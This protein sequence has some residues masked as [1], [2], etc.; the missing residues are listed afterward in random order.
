M[1]A[2]VLQEPGIDGAC[3]NITKK[4]DEKL[5]EIEPIPTGQHSH[6]HNPHR[7]RHHH[8]HHHE[9]SH[10]SKNENHRAPSETQR[11]HPRSGQR[12]RVSGHNRHGQTG[13]DAQVDTVPPGESVEITQ[14]K[15]L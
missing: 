6:H 9:G 1:Q 5:A 8:R 7:H 10:H 2:S 3:E 4:A 11:H 14:D 15:K 12:H 13:R